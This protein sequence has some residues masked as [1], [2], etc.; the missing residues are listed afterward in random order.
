M[1]L[2]K[3][4]GR[5]REAAKVWEDGGD[6]ATVD[7][8]PGRQRGE[9]LIDG[10]SRNPTARV[11]VVGPIDRERWELAVGIPAIDRPAH[12]QMVRTPAMIRAVPVR[13]EGAAEI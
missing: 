10:G 4:Q 6:V 11:G 12:D 5:V 3:A 13:R 2:H 8:K 1:G 9:V 7:A